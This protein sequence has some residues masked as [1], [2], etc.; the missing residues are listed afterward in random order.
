MYKICRWDPITFGNNIHPVPMIYIKPDQHLLEFSKLNNDKLVVNITSTNTIYDG[1]SL[2]GVICE[3][4]ELPNYRP[5]YFK[6]TD[7]YVIV[8]DAIWNGYPVPG[9]LGNVEIIGMDNVNDNPN[10]N[11]NDNDNPNNR[12]MNMNIEKSNNDG[13]D[14]CQLI[15]VGGCILAI[16]IVL[17]FT[18]N[19][20]NNNENIF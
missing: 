12:K 13:M 9:S 20:K 3:S 5:N 2:D 14:L 7:T 8:L 11:D 19:N 17:F 1:I 15:G 10:N 16:F 6:E 18:S 4:R